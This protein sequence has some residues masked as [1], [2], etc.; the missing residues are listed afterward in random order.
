MTTNGSGQMVRRSAERRLLGRRRRAATGAVFDR[1]MPDDG[2]LASWSGCFD[3]MGFLQ[4]HLR[5]DRRHVR[6]QIRRRLGLWRHRLAA[7]F[8]IH[9][10]AFGVVQLVR[11]VAGAVA[12]LRD[13][14]GIY[15]ECPLPDPAGGKPDGDGLGDGE[16]RELHGGNAVGDRLH[17]GQRRGGGGCDSGGRLGRRRRGADPGVPGLGSVP[18]P[19]RV[20]AICTSTPPS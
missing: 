6:Q 3:V 14:G 12:G 2:K 8:E 9:R 17:G 1:R 19:I 4:L 20:W 16:H 13:C 11:L 7:L 15:P 18:D 10:A 5:R